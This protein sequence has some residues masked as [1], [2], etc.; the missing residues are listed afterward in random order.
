MSAGTTSK[1]SPAI[2]SHENIGA[3]GSVLMATM[4]LDVRMPAMC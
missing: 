4:V 3:S 1:R 2:R